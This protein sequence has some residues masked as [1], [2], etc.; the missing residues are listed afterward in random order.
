[1]PSFMVMDILEKAQDME[2]A[3]STVIHLEVGEPDFD[4]PTCVNEA[5]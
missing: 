3:G 5:I 4:T 1:M 2:R